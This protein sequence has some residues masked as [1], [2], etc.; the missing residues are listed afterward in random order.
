ML[1]QGGIDEGE[2]PAAAAAR[3]LREETGVRSARIVAA[4]PDWLQ[5]DFPPEVL[6]ICRRDGRRSHRGQR[7]AWCVLQASTS[8][9]LKHL[10]VPCPAAY[11]LVLLFA[12]AGDAIKPGISLLGNKGAYLAQLGH[13]LPTSPPP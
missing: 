4:H 13:R 10:H 12:K 11:V 3:E 6:A 2:D 7:Q 8:H 1:R 5:Y 9:T